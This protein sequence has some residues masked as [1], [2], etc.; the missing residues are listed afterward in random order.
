MNNLEQKKGLRIPFGCLIVVASLAMCFNA[1][2]FVNVVGSVIAGAT[3]TPTQDAV[4]IQSLALTQAWLSYTKT[5]LALPTA[6]PTATFTASP[7]PTL[8]DTSTPLPTRTFTPVPS[9]TPLPYVPP[10]QPAYPSNITAVFRD[11]T[12]S[13]SKTASGTCSGHGGV[14]IWVNH[15]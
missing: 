15:P 12:Y 2:V 8:A 14:S 9:V 13:Y 4:E 10:Q 7:S 3:P 11:G 5:A 6:S 1:F